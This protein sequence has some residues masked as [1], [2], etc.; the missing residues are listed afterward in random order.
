LGHRASVK[1]FISFQFLNLKTVGRTPWTGGSTNRNVRQRQMQNKQRQISM[2]WV[3]FELMIPVC[4]RAKTV[5][6]LDRVATVFGLLVLH[7]WIFEISEL[8][9]NVVYGI[10][11]AF[12]DTCNFIQD[13]FLLGNNIRKSA[14][15]IFEAYLKRGSWKNWN[16]WTLRIVMRVTEMP[17]V[18]L[19]QNHYRVLKKSGVENRN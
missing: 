19:H 11:F 18:V 9:G 3:G 12:T 16:S 2:P 7:Y 14:N 10:G 13:T 6:V 15:N 1:R 8:Y 17:Y 4:K 5:H